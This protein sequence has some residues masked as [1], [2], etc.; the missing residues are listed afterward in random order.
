MFKVTPNGPNRV[1][2]EIGGKLDSD[3]MRTG[4][5]ALESATAGMENGRMLY[6]IGDFDLPTLG[7]IGVE[8]KRLP[9][10]FGLL[11]T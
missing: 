5:D 8:F 6:R 10:L 3:E 2:I 1:D 9:S 11:P 7:A 4:L